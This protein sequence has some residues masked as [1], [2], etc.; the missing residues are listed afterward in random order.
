MSGPS[1]PPSFTL[2]DHRLRAETQEH[3]QTLSEDL[4]DLPPS[5]AASL[6]LEEA[7]SAASGLKTDSAESAAKSETKQ[8]TGSKAGDDTEPPPPYEEGPSPLDCFVYIMAAA[9]GAASIITQ[10]SQN[11]PTSLSLGGEY[12]MC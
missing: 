7:S 9:G 5:F 4:S 12:K 1:S 11:A 10:V 8:D 3:K 6:A 2:H